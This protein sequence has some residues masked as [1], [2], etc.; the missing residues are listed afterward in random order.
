MDR[1][2]LAE[3]QSERA[4]D[5]TQ[6]DARRAASTAITVR[7]V[8]PSR[9][10]SAIRRR[11]CGTV[12][13]IALNANRNPTSALIAANS[14]VD[15]LLARGGLREQLSL[16]SRSP[17]R[18]AGRAASAFERAL[19]RGASAPGGGLHEDA[20]HATVQ[21]GHFL[22]V[23]TAARAPPGSRPARPIWRC[24]QLRVERRLGR[25]SGELER[26]L[27]G[28]T[29]LTPI[30]LRQRRGQH[31]RA[32]APERFERGCGARACRRA[33]TRLESAP[34]S[35]TDSLPSGP[36]AFALASSSGAAMRTPGMA[37]TRASMLCGKPCG[38][39]ASS[40]SVAS[41][42]IPC[43]SWV[44]EL[45]R[46]ELE[47]CEANSSAT[48]AAMPTTA[49]H[50]CHKPRAQAHAIEAQAFAVSRW[51]ADRMGGSP[52]CIRARACRR[53]VWR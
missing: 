51:P 30:V 8:Y 13:S 52:A 2:L 38:S 21:A 32:D 16:R 44:T 37:R 29:S 33:L 17:R 10:R 23:A 28:R 25:V 14:A 45:C 9:R 43:E 4:R 19:A 31:D 20:A 41:P 42:A 36:I 48:P 49:K 11:R 27:P 24:V 22:R 46:L 53:A 39:R 7:G 6:H 34:I 12:S 50:S 18:S 15:W 26:R 40:C 3:C 47:T 35:S 5:H 1:E